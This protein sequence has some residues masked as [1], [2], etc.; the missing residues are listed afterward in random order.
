MRISLLSFLLWPLCSA[1]N[2]APLTVQSAVHMSEPDGAN[3]AHVVYSVPIVRAGNPAIAARI[4]AAF[5]DAANEREIGTKTVAG[6][7]RLYLTDA[8]VERIKQTAA[9]LDYAIERN[10]GRVLTISVEGEYCGAYCEGSTEYFSFDASTGQRLTLINLLAPGGIVTLGKRIAAL[11]VARINRQI[12]QLKSG[13]T[14]GHPS[15]DVTTAIDMYERCRQ[16]HAAPDL[17]SGPYLGYDGLNIGPNT[18][19]FTHERCSPHV[20][21]ALDD[22]GEFETSFAFMELKPYLSDY[23]KTLL[24]TR[25]SEAGSAG[26]FSKVLHGHIGGRLAITMNLDV[27]GND[28]VSGH[29]FY[30]KYRTPILLAGQRRGTTLVLTEVE[31]EHVP[32]P[33]MTL[34][35]DGSKLEGI[36]KGT[37]SLAF[38]AAP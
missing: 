16:F 1:L 12:A 18:L 27:D 34:V 21:R 10:D 8:T 36:W 31:S 19:T 24:L 22:I 28:R 11:R 25:G 30:D 5:T 13:K 20:I 33:T 2:A 38:A 9:S 23:G 37:A 7:D 32:Q 29:Y 14:D 3:P 26:P 17:D 15:E 4:N 6:D 35:I